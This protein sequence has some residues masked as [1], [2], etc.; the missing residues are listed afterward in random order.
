MNKH[1]AVRTQGFT[2]IELLIVI[3]II[4]ILA[5]I[6]IPSFSAARKRPYDV[7][8]LQCGKAVVAA[9]ITY[10][11]EHNETAAN[12][13]AQLNNTD[14]NEQC[15][16]AGVQVTKDNTPP[17]GMA[18]AGDNLIGVAGSNYAFDVWHRS[19]TGI[20]IYNRDL[21]TDHFRKIN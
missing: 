16:G 13:I 5:A 14:V 10:I 12:S 15:A 19:G 2:L 18:A 17:A 8:A 6:M 21:A 4:A 11:A 9:Q 3:A 1:S 7:S 20:Y